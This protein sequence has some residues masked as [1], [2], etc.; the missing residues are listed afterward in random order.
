[1]TPLAHDLVL[2]DADGST[3]IESLCGEPFDV[4][5]VVWPIPDRCP[6]CAAISAHGLQ[7]LAGKPSPTSPRTDMHPFWFNATRLY[8]GE[9]EDVHVPMQSPGR[10]AAHTQTAHH[11]QPTKDE[12]TPK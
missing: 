3:V 4:S 7:A 9:C 11:R 8:C 5:E 2:I 1:M 12:R 6:V 10:L